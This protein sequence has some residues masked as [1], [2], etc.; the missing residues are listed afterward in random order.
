M[1]D[2]LHKQM[3]GHRSD[4]IDN[5]NNI[6][7]QHFNQS[8]HLIFSIRVHINETIFY[9]KLARFSPL[10]IKSLRRQYITKP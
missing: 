8:D 7:Y 2:T 4:I 5:V 9:F 6:A 1:K 10:H 3:Y